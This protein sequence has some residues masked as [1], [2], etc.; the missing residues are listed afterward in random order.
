[1]IPYIEPKGGGKE[2]E[3]RPGL[4]A[5]LPRMAA[6]SFKP[7]QL[8]LWLRKLAVWVVTADLGPG[9]G[10]GHSNRRARSR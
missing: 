8:V 4:W 2:L 10:P 1:M 7:E 3:R 6:P 5:V 9:R